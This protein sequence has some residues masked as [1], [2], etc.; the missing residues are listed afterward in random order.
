MR[1]K[2]KIIFGAILWCAL[3]LSGP[4]VAQGAAKGSAKDSAKDSAK[5]SAKG[6]APSDEWKALN[7]EAANL[8]FEGKFEAGLVAAKKALETAER[9]P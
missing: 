1:T 4:A 7:Q 9:P 3:L 2:M 6:A 5:G 8:F